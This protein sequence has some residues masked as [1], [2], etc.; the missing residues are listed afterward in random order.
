MLSTGLQIAGGVDHDHRTDD[1]HQQSEHQGP[2]RPC[3]P[4]LIVGIQGTHCS[5][6]GEPEVSVE[7]E[8]A[9]VGER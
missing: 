4:T 3:R 9:R 8:R 1:Q 6:T 5:T 2:G 7:P